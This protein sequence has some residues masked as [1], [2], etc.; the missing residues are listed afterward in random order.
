MED[1]LVA[2]G[3]VLR[4][5]TTGRISGRPARATVGFVEREGGALVVAAGSPDA[6]WGLNLIASPACRVTIGDASWAAVGRLL[7]GAE[8]ATAVR[9]LILRY[10]TPAET[11][12]AGPAFELTPVDPAG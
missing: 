12:G 4:I 11:L 8:H 10:G 5:E 2:W 7:T 1:D 6:D 9:D 3:R